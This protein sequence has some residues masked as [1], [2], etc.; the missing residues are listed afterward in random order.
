MGEGGGD[1]S[2]EEIQ[3]KGKNGQA[4]HNKVKA[5]LNGKLLLSDLRAKKYRH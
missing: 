1:G 3:L 2:S 4:M 5:G